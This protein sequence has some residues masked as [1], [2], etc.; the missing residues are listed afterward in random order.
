MYIKGD[1]TSPIAPNNKVITHICNDIGG[2]DMI[3]KQNQ[4]YRM[5]NPLFFWY[6]WQTI[7]YIVFLRKE[8]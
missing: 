1:A 8:K 6:I 7:F 5:S 3:Y 2:W 4:H